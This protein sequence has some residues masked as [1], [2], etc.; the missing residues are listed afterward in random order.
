MNEFPEKAR[1][2]GSR[3]VAKQCHQPKKSPFKSEL[4]RDGSRERSSQE[5]E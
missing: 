2:K 4:E 1:E 5:F 3:A